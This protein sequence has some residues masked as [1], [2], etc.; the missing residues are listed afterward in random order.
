M[1][2]G[3]RRDPVMLLLVDGRPA[4]DGAA[5]EESLEAMNTANAATVG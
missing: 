5:L 1:E 2:V 4:W 3:E